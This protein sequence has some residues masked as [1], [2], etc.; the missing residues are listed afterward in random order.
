MRIDDSKSLYGTEEGIPL[1]ILTVTKICF[2]HFYLSSVS[3]NPAVF[4]RRKKKRERKEEKILS[5]LPHN[6]K[7]SAKSCK[8]SP[9]NNDRSA[10]DI[11]FFRLFDRC[12]FDAG[13]CYHVRNIYASHA[14]PSWYDCLILQGQTDLHLMSRS[15]MHGAVTSI[16][17]TLNYVC[18]HRPLNL[19]LH[20]PGLLLYILACRFVARQRPRNK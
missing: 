16:N 15:G 1:L 17:V 20:I 18:L 3:L 11:S 12:S 10:T 14:L 8:L 9:R 7:F 5:H 13:M 4:R 2:F 6:S 19:C